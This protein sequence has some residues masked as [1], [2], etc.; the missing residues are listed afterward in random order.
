MVLLR[1]VALLEEYVAVGVEFEVSFAQVPL[2][3]T[4]SPLPVAYSQLQHHICL[5]TVMP[6]VMMIMD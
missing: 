3:A 1:G 5:N 4:V 2:I 6:S